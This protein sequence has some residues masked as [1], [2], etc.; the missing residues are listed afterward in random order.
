MI[1][2]QIRDPR[3]G[4]IWAPALRPGF[5]PGPGMRLGIIRPAP[6]D[7]GKAQCSFGEKRGASVGGGTPAKEERGHRACG[8]G[9]GL[10]RGNADDGI[11]AGGDKVNPTP[12]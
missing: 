6:A 9:D 1:R 8:G 3:Q 10:C 12:E 11:G 2:P 4:R 5:V 7:P